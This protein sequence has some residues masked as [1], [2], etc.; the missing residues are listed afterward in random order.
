MQSLFHTPAW[1]S[2]P[3]SVVLAEDPSPHRQGNRGGDG[4]AAVDHR[5]LAEEYDLAVTGSHL[6]AVVDDSR[7]TYLGP[8][9][10]NDLPGLPNLDLARLHQLSN[11]RAKCLAGRAGR[12]Q[13]TVANHPC[14]FFFRKISER[15][16]GPPTRHDHDPSEVEIHFRSPRGDR[17]RRFGTGR[18]IRNCCG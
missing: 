18:T 16:Y 8:D 4:T 12:K 5:M 14:L 17:V 11:R 15:W 10:R 13:M 9:G 3:H 2:Q 1:V 7:E 6:Y